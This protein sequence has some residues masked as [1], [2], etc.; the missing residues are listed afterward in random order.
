MYIDLSVALGIPIA[1]VQ[2]RFVP[3][4]EPELKDWEHT[5]LRLASMRS[6]KHL[7]LVGGIVMNPR[8]GSLSACWGQLVGI[9]D[10][11]NTFD[12]QRF[13]AGQVWRAVGKAQML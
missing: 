4:T 3:V 9:L 2:Q 5:Y 13:E 6:L 1:L 12:M 11:L 10:V 8:P 7:R